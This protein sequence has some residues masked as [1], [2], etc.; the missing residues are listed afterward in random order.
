[1]LGG[2]VTHVIGDRQVTADSPYLA[3]V[4]AGVP[5]HIHQRRFG[6]DQHHRR[7]SEQAA[8]LHR[9]GAEPTRE[10]PV[11]ARAVRARPTTPARYFFVVAAITMLA[12]MVAGFHPYYLRGEGLAGRKI[13]PP[14]A[15][16]V[17]VH[18]TAMTAWL[19]IFLVQSLLVPARRLRM[20]MKLGWGGV[21]VALVAAASGF[22]L[23]VE[24]VRPVPAIPFWGMAY[25]QFM[26]VMLSEV[27]LFAV[28]V[29][30]G[31]FF[32]KRPKI[33]KAMMLLASLS[34]L[35]G[36]TVR[37]PVLFS[38]FGEAG[39]SGIFGPI[40][41]LGAVF[42]LIRSLLGGAT[43]RGLAAGYVVMVVVYVGACEFAVSDAWSTLARAVLNE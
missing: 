26:L 7:V 37:M 35:A 23:A 27:A 11:T 14:L 24:S 17:F 12:I 2:R 36:A 34:I 30:A 31:V 15:M 28:F 10:A 43:D 4:P 6:A 1:V 33:H 39:W 18:G 29:L 20:H 22:M 19:T 32:R 8:R 25:R 9:T 16:L 40:F 42:V 21:A 3:R 38:V 41:V 5:S 13:A